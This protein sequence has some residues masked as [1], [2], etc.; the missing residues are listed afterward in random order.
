LNKT[1]T[2]SI[3]GSGKYTLVCDAGMGHWSVFFKPL[4]ALLIYDCKIC[5]IDRS[6]Y[7]DGFLPTSKRLCRQ[8][9]HEIHS[10]LEKMDIEGPM[11]LVGHS[12]GG[13]YMRM[14]YELF[15]EKIKGMILLD[16]AHPNLPEVIPSLIDNIQAQQ[17]QMK[18]IT[19]LAS[20]GL[21]RMF[22]SFIPTFGLPEVFLG[23]YYAVT[24]KANYYRL[25]RMEMEAFQEN[26]DQCK[27]LGSLGTLP[28]LVMGCRK[29]PSQAFISDATDPTGNQWFSLQQDLAS[30]STSSTFVQSTKGHFFPISDREF[31]A[32]TILTFLSKL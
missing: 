22:K 6:G 31:V 11:I 26:F 19:C 28:L 14:Y 9:A 30:L 13:L 2:Y 21:L 23:E 12:L 24:V 10:V 1:K 8:V 32:K 27:S 20:I 18:T 4:A 17:Q 15:P 5:L 29:G 25:Y 3:I 7:T 16:A